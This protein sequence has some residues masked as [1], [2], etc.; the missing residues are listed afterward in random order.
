MS[1][2]ASAIAN[3]IDTARPPGDLLEPEVC[4]FYFRPAADDSLV[5]M[6]LRWSARAGNVHPW[7]LPGGITIDG[8]A[9]ERFGFLLRR[10]AE[11]AYL[12][13]V[14]WDQASLHWLD[15]TRR[16][17]LDTSFPFVLNAIGTDL[18]YLLDQPVQPQTTHIKKVA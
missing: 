18:N 4:K 2:S 7:R 8:P 12:L 13:S 1:E 5:S 9:P 17:I 10:H 16:Q 15:L 14:V 3:Q 11:D 6:H